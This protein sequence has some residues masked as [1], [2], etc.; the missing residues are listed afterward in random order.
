MLAEQL[1]GE[2]EVWTPSGFGAW[3]VTALNP[4][5]ELLAFAPEAVYLLLDGHFATAAEREQLA[6]SSV[7]EAVAA[8]RRALPG[9][10]VVVPKLGELMRDDVEGFYDERMWKLAAMPWSARGLAAIGSLFVLRKALALD[11][12]GT[13]WQGTIGEVGRGGI[14]PDDEFQRQLKALAARGILLTVLSKNNPEDVD[15]AGMPL[16]AADFV[17]SEVGWGAK[18]DGLERLAAKLNLGTEAFVFV[19]DNPV[20]RAEMRARHPEVAVVGSPAAVGDFFPERRLT[21]ED[22]LRVRSYQAEA[23]RQAAAAVSAADYLASLKMWTEIRPLAASEVPRVAQLSQKT[24]QFNVLTH[25]YSEAEVR[26]FMADPRRLVLTARAGDRFGDLGLISFVQVCGNEIVD[27]V[28]SCRAMNRGIEHEVLARLRQ[29][30]AAR[31]LGEVRA[32][33]RRTAKNAPVAEL[34]ERLG[35]ERI[36]GDE[37]EKSYRLKLD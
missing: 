1:R 35:F 37:S 34:Y 17:A 2:H 22:R 10:P 30:L 25:R 11:L 26:E 18:A 14:V 12:D 7:A 3:M 21:A 13:L 6:E 32:R 29:E 8:L 31:G 20:E 5:P 19:D 36:A 27:W 15:F 24:N 16:T 28:M 23:A 4:P 33:W 9:V